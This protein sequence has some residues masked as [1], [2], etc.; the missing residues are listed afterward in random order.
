MKKRAFFLGLL[1][2]AAATSGCAQLLS[3]YGYG[4]GYRPYPVV[5]PPVMPVDASAAARGRWDQV[6]R[7]PAGAVID[8]LTRDSSAYVGLLRGTDGL[9]V[10]VM[11]NGIEEQIARGDVLR[12]DLVDLPGSEVGAVAKRATAGALLGLGA[13]ALIGGV[14]GGEAWPPPGALL[15]GGAAIGGVAGGEAALVARQGRLIYLAENQMPLVRSSGRAGGWDPAESEPARIVE[16]YAVQAWSA[17]SALPVGEMVRVVRMNGWRH[18]GRLAGVDDASLRL[19]VEGA[20]L[21]ITRASIVRVEVLQTEEALTARKRMSKLSPAPAVTLAGAVVS[22]D[23]IVGS[24][25]INS[26]PLVRMALPMLPFG[27][28]QPQILQF[29]VAP[30]H[31]V[32]SR[33]AAA[34]MA[35]VQPAARPMRAAI[36]HGQA[37]SLRMR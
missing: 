36:C 15:R 35:N 23:G 33:D 14:I 8:V 32:T 6:M 22:D 28:A 1:L 16:S 34:A 21:R 19:D 26:A 10:R 25:G 18:R 12:V 5:R 20:E 31:L 2:A 29:Q 7:L 37:V 24:V 13:A 3:P 9:N 11:V 27:G 17:I 4:R 30:L